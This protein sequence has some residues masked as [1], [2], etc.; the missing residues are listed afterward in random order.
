MA[1]VPTLQGPSFT[2]KA[3]EGSKLKKLG[4]IQLY[5]YA[6]ANLSKWFDLKLNLVASIF[7]SF[8]FQPKIR[9]F[10]RGTSELK[11]GR[12]RH[13]MFRE[14]RKQLKKI[15]PNAV[16]NFDDT[17]YTVSVLPIDIS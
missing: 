4:L 7:R 14:T 2:H 16:K 11:F 15:D 5:S 9:V 12:L 8:N 13:E 1:G 17:V 6:I 10:Q 3:R